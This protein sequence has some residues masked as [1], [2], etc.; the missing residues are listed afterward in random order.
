ML[1]LSNT[2][3]KPLFHNICI[4]LYIYLSIYL[5]IKYYI[6]KMRFVQS[7]IYPINQFHLHL[8]CTF[9]WKFWHFPQFEFC[10]EMEARSLKSVSF[11]KQ[12]SSC[13]SEYWKQRKWFFLF[14]VGFTEESITSHEMKG[15]PSVQRRRYP[16]QQRSKCDRDA[17]A[18]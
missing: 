9:L 5:Y 16:S 13:M 14:M 7:I 6:Y 3:Q 11:W 2:F 15:E 8:Y 10:V 12:V 1:R 17:S 18:L 4:H